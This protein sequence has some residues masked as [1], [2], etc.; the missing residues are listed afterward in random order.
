MER[1]LKVL[2]FLANNKKN[3]ILW[4]SF[5]IVIFAFMFP[6][7]DLGEFVSSQVSKLTNNSITLRFE[8]LKMSLLPHPGFQFHQVYIENAG[9]PA[10]SAQD[11]VITPSISGLIRKLPY[12]IV[13]TTGLFKGDLRLSLG[14]GS[15]TE[16]GTSR[17]KLN[18]NGKNLSLQNIRDL[19]N[20]PVNL[21]GLVDLDIKDLQADVNFVEQP[22]G[23][24]VILIK[25]FE[26]PTTN[27]P[28]QIGT[29]TLPEIKL[30]KVEL[31][32]RLVGGKLTI[33]SGEIGQESDEIYGSLKLNMGLSFSMIGSFP[34]PQAGAYNVELDLIVKKSFQEKAG[35]FLSFLDS[36]KR[37]AA[38]GNQY[39]LRVSAN[40]PGAVPSL[41]GF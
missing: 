9:F 2:K 14:S 29:L 4:L 15:N 17:H 20:L 30:S 41:T 25:N 31:H 5:S 13:S 27:L 35:L 16:S 32:G 24:I 26:L 8:K 18:L 10:I 22:D 1:V 19:M 39:R 28:T 37:T 6:F 12:G 36:Y 34:S 11:L 3:F 40:A 38:N 7:D 23:E 21:R 33:T